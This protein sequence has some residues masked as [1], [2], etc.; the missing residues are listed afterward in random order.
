MLKVLL[1]DDNPTQLHVR[2]AVLVDAGM[3]VST[4]GTSEEALAL[5]R[6]PSAA[7]F[8]VIVTDHMLPG[9]SGAAFVRQL[10]AVQAEVPVLAISGLPEAQEE[11]EGLN[12]RFLPKPVPPE[13]LISCV[14]ELADGASSRAATQD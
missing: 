13:E 8:D 14:R 11:Y 7:R 5:L 10:R 3:Y 12:V 2:E 1:I 9:E 6:P 4:A